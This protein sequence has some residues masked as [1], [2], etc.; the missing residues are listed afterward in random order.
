LNSKTIKL[1]EILHQSFGEISARLPF[2]NSFFK[3]M[4]FWDYEVALN[5]KNRE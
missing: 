1:F 4:G 5:D 2:N 3:E